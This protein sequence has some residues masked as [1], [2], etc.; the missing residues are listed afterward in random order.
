MLKI[1][2]S[3]KN[4][5]EWKLVFGTHTHHQTTTAKSA[6][7]TSGSIYSEL[8]RSFTWCTE[9]KYYYAV[10]LRLNVRT[11]QRSIYEDSMN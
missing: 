5:K 1:H 2:K 9:K 6:F 7:E 3:E 4:E 10:N 11:R 8:T